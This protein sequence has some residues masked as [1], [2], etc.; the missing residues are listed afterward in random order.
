MGSIYKFINIYKYKVMTLWSPRKQNIKTIVLRL[1]GIEGEGD[2]WQIELSLVGRSL[3]FLLD[4]G[5]GGGGC[6]DRHR[7]TAGGFAIYNRS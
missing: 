3:G 4:G 6:D 7:T 2:G 1:K 5:G